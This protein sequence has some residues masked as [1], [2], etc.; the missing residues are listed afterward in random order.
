MSARSRVFFTADT[1]FGHAR[2]MPKRP[3]ATAEEMDQALIERWNAAVSPKDHVYHLGD[4]AWSKPRVVAP[5]LAA[6]NGR[7]TLIRGNHDH[8][9]MRALSVWTDV[10]DIKEIMANG[11]RVVLCHY[12]LLEWNGAF[13]GALHLFGHVHGR[14]PPT[15]QRCDVGVDCWD[16]R[17]VSMPEIRARLAEAPAHDVR[18]PYAA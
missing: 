6:L 16:F 10:F 3:F 18:A 12:P 8:S 5:M 9:P 13:R 1:H 11:V 15:S 14:I 2:L 7:K 4:V 17:P